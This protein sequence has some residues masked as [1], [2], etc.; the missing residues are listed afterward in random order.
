MTLN[1]NRATTEKRLKVLYIEDNLINIKLMKD[2]FSEFLPYEFI[3]STNAKEGLVLAKEQNPQL[4]LM[5]INMDGMS[6]YEAMKNMK[7]DADLANISVIA[8]SGDATP[9]HAEKALNKG[10]AG[11]ITKPLNIMSFIETIKGHMDFK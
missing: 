10:F 7:S 2:I 11:Y 1:N 8:V 5:D 4:I 9:E 6:G 3:S